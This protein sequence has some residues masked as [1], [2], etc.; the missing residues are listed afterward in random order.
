MTR[1]VISAFLFFSFS[2][3]SQVTI[4]SPYSPNKGALLDLKQEDKKDG[5][6]NSKKGLGLPRVALVAIDTLDP[7]VTGADDVSK[8][9]HIGLTVYNT[10]DNTDTDATLTEGV[11][12]WDGD[13]WAKY[14]GGSAASGFNALNGLSL[15]DKNVILG[16]SL[17]RNTTIS[18]TNTLT[19]DAPTT[20]SKTLAV[21]GTTTLAGNLTSNGIT[22]LKNTNVTGNLVVTGSYQTLNSAVAGNETIGGTLGVTGATTLNDV[23]V[24]TTAAKKIAKVNGK[25][26]VSDT[27]ILANSTALV[28]DQ[29]GQ[30]GTAASIPTK[31][32]FL[33]SQI[34]TEIPQASY[35]S[36]NSGSHYTVPWTTGDAATNNG[37]ITINADN[38][39]TVV[40]G[41]TYEISGYSN[42]SFNYIEPI[43]DA[44]NLQK[45]FM[46]LIS[47]QIQENGSSNWNDFTSARYK[48][49]PTPNVPTNQNLLALT[50]YLPFPSAVITLK[51]GDKLRVTL[52]NP[53]A[54]R[55][56]F[57][58]P[59]YSTSDRPNISAATGGKFSRGLK[60]QAL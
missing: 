10:T 49:Y 54:G 32:A 35:N 59:T 47:V 25:L 21:T 26:Y 23:T 15:E 33:Q 18:G 12:A 56:E 24:G 8:K 30:I 2:S 13:I 39:I 11:Y 5:S 7:C 14:T 20:V 16:G 60:V 38:T 36:M 22:E 6:A 43:P 31:V 55:G 41:G 51:A 53:M 57:N 42:W 46:V 19:F 45:A 48:I 58:W 52:R 29:N 40:N 3:Y 37:V 34:K 9:D 17:D 27:P 44:N 1:F 50:D 4:G 28:V